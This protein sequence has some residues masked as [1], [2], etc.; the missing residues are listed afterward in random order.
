MPMNKDNVSL[1]DKR[2]RLDWACNTCKDCGL[3]VWESENGEGTRSL[4][5][6]FEALS[7][8]IENQDQ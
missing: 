6:S 1:I 3:V 5:L 2:V 4:V 7:Y 8:D